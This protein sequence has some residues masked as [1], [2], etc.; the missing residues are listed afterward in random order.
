VTTPLDD[1][2]ARAELVDI[3]A[4]LNT[5]ADLIADNGQTDMAVGIRHATDHVAEILR[6][7]D[8]LPRQAA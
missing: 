6:R 1:H 4:N 5:F 2:A 8:I 7:W 3:I